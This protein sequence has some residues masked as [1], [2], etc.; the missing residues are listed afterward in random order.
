MH[1]VNAGIDAGFKLAGDI[2]EDPD[3]NQ[4]PFISRDGNS[5]NKRLKR[6][7]R[8]FIKNNEFDTLALMTMVMLLFKANYYRKKGDYI[9]YDVNSVV[10]SLLE[11]PA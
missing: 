10:Y 6:R 11:N 4:A 9:L 3:F 7:S 1:V 5:I 8:L 2:L